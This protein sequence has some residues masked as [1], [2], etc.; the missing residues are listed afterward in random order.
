MALE[1]TVETPF[2]KVSR[3]TAVLAVAGGALVILVVW[4]R[5]RQQEPATTIPPSE[6]NP[7]TGYPYGS[8]EDAMALAQQ[9]AYISP[10]TGPGGG[11]STPP[12]GSGFTTNAQWSQA[13][14]SYM[15][16]AGVV[17]DPAMLS[18]ALGKY[19]AGQPVSSVEQSLV[20]QAIAVQGYPPVAGATGYPPAVRVQ[21]PVTPPPPAPGQTARLPAPANFRD[22][23]PV[24]TTWLEYHWDPVPGAIRYEFTDG[25][26]IWSVGNV[27]GVMRPGLVHNGTYFTQ[28]RAVDAMNRPGAWSPTLVSRTKN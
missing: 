2:G 7:A 13:V 3:R 1:G 10:P 5:M 17:A 23:G 26:R 15:T 8:A 21:A 4:L 22:T 16:S 19:I 11:A 14:I 12:A 28:V 25:G 18:G 6:V 20:H 9:A 27:T 24:W